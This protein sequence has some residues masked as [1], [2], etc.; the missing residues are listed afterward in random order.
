MNL[1]KFLEDLQQRIGE[2]AATSP[3]KDVERNVRAMMSSAFAKLDLVPRDELD[4]QAKVLQRT[5]ERL[6][7]LERRVAE[8][9]SRLGERSTVDR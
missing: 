7:A 6:E 9:E 3:A 8:L 2:L 5:R 4:V 1:P